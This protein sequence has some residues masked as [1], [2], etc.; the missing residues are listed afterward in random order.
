MVAASDDPVRD[1]LVTSL[2]PPGSNITGLTFAVSP[3]IAGKQLE[4][5][6]EMAPTANRVRL[7]A[8]ADTLA[9][10]HV[11]EA[12]AEAAPRL[13]SRAQEPLTAREVSQ[14]DE[15]FGRAVR[16]RTDAVWI[17]MVGVT[18]AQRARVAELALRH[19]VPVLG[20]FRSLP[21]AGGLF[22]YGP[23]L[24]DIYRR[25]AGY[26]DRVLRGARPADLPIEQPTKFELVLN[27]RT[28]KTLGLTIPQSVLLRADEVIR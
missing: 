6:R 18:F 12:I 22:S 14:F 20:Y 11:A 27:L 13:H 24:R 21:E 4:L 15:A 19:R 1:G 26:V 8:D 3:E 16:E 5:L 23:D 28:A 7:L 10:R 2:A 9:P 25:A 17:P